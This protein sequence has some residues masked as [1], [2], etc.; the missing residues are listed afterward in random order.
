MQADGTAFPKPSFVSASG[1][2]VFPTQVLGEIYKVQPTYRIYETAPC[3][4]QGLQSYPQ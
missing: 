4:H 2:Y 1:Y 3:R